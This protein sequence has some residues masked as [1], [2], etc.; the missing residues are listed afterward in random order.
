MEKY[1][2]YIDYRMFINFNSNINSVLFTF[3]EIDLENNYDYLTITGSSQYQITG[4]IDAGGML[5]VSPYGH[6]V[7]LDFDADISNPSPH[8]GF[9]I[10]SI[11]VKC[12]SSQQTPSYLQI[13]E[14]YR[15]DGILLGSNDVNY[16]LVEHL[17][18]Y[19]TNI[20]MNGYN[21]GDFDLYVKKDSFPTSTSYYKRSISY[22][23]DEAIR[24]T[25]SAQTGY[26]YI[27]IPSYS[28][29]GQYSVRVSYTKPEER[30]LIKVGTNFN[31]TTAQMDNITNIVDV[32]LKRFFGYTSGEIY[33]YEADIYNSGNCNCGGAACNVCFRAGCGRAY[34]TLPL[35]SHT[36]VMYYDSADSFTLGHEMGHAWPALPDEYHNVEPKLLD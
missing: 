16:Y 10:V 11:G 6:L 32:A 7:M 1:L 25:T 20:V 35:G 24:L 12:H 5:T 2:N 30:Y 27:A 17:E 31:A 28:G 29:S 19:E 34:S 8:A 18:G 22:N 26:Y 33:I 21:N 36:V 15:Y 3:G 13:F 4:H 14:N 9:S 23:S